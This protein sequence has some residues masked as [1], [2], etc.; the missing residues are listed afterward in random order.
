V[1]VRARSRDKN[2]RLQGYVKSGREIMSKFEQVCAIS[3]AQYIPLI[4]EVLPLV[5][6][7]LQLN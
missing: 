6:S 7:Q 4:M 1:Q 5:N 3:V 2:A